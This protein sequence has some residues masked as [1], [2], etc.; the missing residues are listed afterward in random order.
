MRQRGFFMAMLVVVVMVLAA[1]MPSAA[2][3]PQQQ[4]I[5]VTSTADSGP[6]TLREA[7]ERA[8][9]GNTIT[10]DPAV[11]PPD[12]PATIS[13]TSPLPELSQGQVTID[14]SD[15][16]VILGGSQLPREEGI[17]GLTVV[18]NGNVIRGLQILHFPENGLT[19]QGSA[20]YNT[21]GGDWA[22]G[23][24]PTGQGNMMSGNDIQGIHIE[25]AG[26][27]H[28]LVIG[29]FIGTDS[30]GTSALGNGFHGVAIVQGAQN[31]QIGGA[32]A[33]ERNIISGNVWDGVFI[34]ESGTMY[35]AV[36]GNYIGTNASGTAPIPNENFGVNLGDNTRNNLVGGDTAAEGN[37]I[38]GNGAGGVN[39]AGSGVRDNT[40][41]GNLIG[42]DVYGNQ[43]LPNFFGVIIGDGASYTSV[44]G[45]V[46]SGN[47]D[48]VTIADAGTT[49][50]TISGNFIGTNATGDATVGNEVDG[51]WIGVGAQ[52]NVIG[53]STPEERNIISGNGN[54]GAVIDSS[55]HNT[56][57]GNYIGTDATGTVALGNGNIGVVLAWGAQHNLIGGS[58][59][60]ER[61][62][63]SGNGNDGVTIGNRDTMSNT[64]SG[65]YI[66]TDVTGTQAI[67]NAGIGVRINDGA[68]HNVVGGTTPGER[69][70]ISGNG[71]NG[72]NIE[73]SETM[74]NV[75][76]GSYIGTDFTG[77]MAL[78]NVG[79]GVHV[80]N[81]AGPNIIGPGNIIAYNGE[82]GVSVLGDDTLGNTIT[83][84]SIYGNGGLGVQI[85]EG[86]NAELSAPTI[87]YVSTRTI[88]GTAPPNSRVEIFFDEKEQGRIFAGSTVAD[89]EGNFVYS[90]P[91]GIF[92]G[93]NVTATTVDGEGNTS[94]LSAPQS[95]RAPVVTRELPGIVGPTQVSLEPEVVGTNLGLALFCVLFFGLT[96][97]IFNSILKDYRDELAGAFGRLVP[98]A[99]IDAISRIG[100]SLGGMA[101]NGRDRL[102]LMWL[103]VLLL[104]SF[105]ES[106]LDPE[107][108]V[109]SPERLGLLITLFVS[110]VA[111]SGL[112][113][114]S[115]LLAYRRWAPTIKAESKVQWA[116]IAIAL[117]CVIL[118]RALDFK[119][120]YLYGAVGAIY[121]VPKLV[122]IPS[123]GKRAALVLVIILAGGFIL[124]I[125]TAFLPAVLAELEPLLLT[126]FLISLQGV[127]FALLP[128]A[129]TD[130]GDIWSWRKGVWFVFFAV[131]FFCFYHFLLNPNASDVEA[132]QQ[133]GVQTLLL[134]I[135]IFGLAT[136]VLWLLLPFRLRRKRLTKK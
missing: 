105:I 116:G 75:V 48:G 27:D 23:A 84:N 123:S 99:A 133:N 102:L 67:G 51:V 47:Y 124:W 42:V 72:V 104:T 14:A 125:A 7:L 135:V 73:H 19:I 28:N 11:F 33:G 24:G 54:N 25:G 68:Q 92:A 78:G 45:N 35:N 18:S 2:A 31:N 46:V 122:G 111:V 70:L 41:R 39:V 127:F 93:P 103:L 94:Q 30:T 36:S 89:E 65:N 85:W 90:V 117:A 20:Q 8:S 57:S 101:E 49:S 17:N 91:V 118:S 77:T 21:I 86:G 37:V 80:D 109:F 119:P 126:I 87:I 40:I 61:N 106:F 16:G 38:S 95:P 43:P 34:H 108:G 53:G 76:T 107:A 5:V 6:G 62:I 134:L 32:T 10:F 110:G 4:D 71:R 82:S 81:G 1:M 44:Q 98:Q 55:A 136:L 66:G 60:E 63:I 12:D 64:I 58:T 128:L 97:N 3:A 100:S 83:G 29:N 112:E 113:L 114:G 129:F 120:G 56:V 131:V 9:P 13:L 50:N 22:V 88:R 74:W 69:N 130:G 132:L 79:H 15:A 26:T 52:Y 121:L 115:D 59:P 96:S